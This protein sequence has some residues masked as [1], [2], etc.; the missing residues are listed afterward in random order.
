M[1]FLTS[2]G[3][4]RDRVRHREAAILA[5]FRGHAA[6][7]WALWCLGYLPD[8]RGRL[9]LGPALLRVAAVIAVW[10]VLLAG[11]ILFPDVGPVDG[12][13]HAEILALLLNLVLPGIILISVMVRRLHDTGRSGWA[14]L[15]SVFPY[16]GP[17]IL[18]YF[19]FG[20]SQPGANA[21]GAPPRQP[22]Y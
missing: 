6:G 8:F 12:P 20:S 18:L 17:L 5:S 1:S 22:T 3:T 15:V 11:L 19:L 14:L 2:L 16:V 21:Y 13:N 4:F 7:R 10:G 9:T